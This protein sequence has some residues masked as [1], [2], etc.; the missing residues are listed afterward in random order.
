MPWTVRKIHHAVLNFKFSGTNHYVE[1]VAL[2]IDISCLNHVFA[3]RLHWVNYPFDYFR[4]PPLYW[5]Y[6]HV[7]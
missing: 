3:W 1:Y 2:L 6:C 5:I 4:K 7:S